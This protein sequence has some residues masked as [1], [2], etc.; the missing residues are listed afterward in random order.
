MSVANLQTLHLLVRMVVGQ[1]PTST[2]SWHAQ[3]TFSFVNSGCRT[4]IT[5]SHTLLQA[6]PSYS[7]LLSPLRE[8]EL[9]LGSRTPT[10]GAVMDAGGLMKAKTT[11]SH[12]RVCMLAP[13]LLLA[14]PLP[15]NP[16]P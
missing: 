12:C 1:R 15:L 8:H 5:C 4:I 10:W 13:P 3:H 9:R 7:F 6:A 14:D 11:P 2:C 16:K